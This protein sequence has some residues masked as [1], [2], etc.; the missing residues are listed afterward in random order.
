MAAM[1]EALAASHDNAGFTCGSAPLDRFLHRHAVAAQ[2]AGGSRT[3]VLAEGA[4]IHGYYSLAVGSVDHA[5]APSRVI[6][7]MA[8]HAIP[9]MLL[10]RLAV[11]QRWQGSGIG[12]RLL[13]DA[14]MRTG[15]VAD[16]A[17]LRALLV[18]AK[19][20]AARRWYLRF[21]FEPSPTDPLHLFLLIKDLKAA[22]GR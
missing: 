7:G 11:D 20:E 14:L 12:Q 3:Y 22:L 2:A 18:H 4:I 17:G 6:K 15:A 10:A 16:I 5:Q 19:D 1:I 13:R 9:V 21:D 8:R